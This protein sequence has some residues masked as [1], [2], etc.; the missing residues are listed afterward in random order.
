MKANLDRANIYVSPEGLDQLPSLEMYV[1]AH[2]GSV[3]EGS[4]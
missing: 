4:A 3:F 2:V 1:R